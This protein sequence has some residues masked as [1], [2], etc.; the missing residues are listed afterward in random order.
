MN[1]FFVHIAL[2]FLIRPLD[3]TTEFENAN[4]FQ[5]IIRRRSTSYNS[6][7][8]VANQVSTPCQSEVFCL[9]LRD[10]GL[11]IV[12]GLP[13]TVLK[14]L[15]IATYTAWHAYRCNALHSVSV[16]DSIMSRH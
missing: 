8:P 6:R 13:R 10:C 12:Y 14:S 15:R 11:L 1:R 5:S 2:H 3:I 9:S 16:Q 4:L 7:F